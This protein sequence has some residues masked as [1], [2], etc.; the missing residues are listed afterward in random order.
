[1]LAAMLS[2]NF[3]FPPGGVD[4]FIF[5]LLALLA[6]LQAVLRELLAFSLHLAFGGQGLL[7]YFLLLQ[8]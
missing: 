3:I 4:Q 2:C 1:M 5:L 8:L 6:D 7:F